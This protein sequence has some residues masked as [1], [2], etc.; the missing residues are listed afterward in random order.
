MRIQQRE[1]KVCEVQAL[2][3]GESVLIHADGPKITVEQDAGLLCISIDFKQSAMGVQ[4]YDG[5]GED[6]GCVRPWGL[7]RSD[8]D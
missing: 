5:N 2:H 1:G 4:L 3:N 6:L 8:E 7:G